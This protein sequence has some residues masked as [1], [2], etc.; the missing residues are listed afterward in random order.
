[1]KDHKIGTTV[2]VLGLRGFPNVQGGVET[3][4]ENLYPLIAKSGIGVVCATRR[5]FHSPDLLEWSGVRF[6]PLWAPKSR[7]LEAIGHSIWAVFRAA[8]MRPSVV[9]IHA[10]GSG[11]VTPLARLFGLRVVVTH[12]GP[13][14]DREK[15]NAF[16]RGILRL[17]EWCGMKFAHERIVISPV[18]EELVSQQ[19]GKTST[20]IPNGVPLP[21][22]EYEEK[23]IDKYG[24]QANKYVLLVSRFVP[25]KRHLD[26]IDAFERVDM[27][28]IKLVLV[29]GAD[30]PDS[31]EEQ[32]IARAGENKNIVLTGILGGRELQSVYQHAGV[33]VLPS[34]HEGLPICLLEALSFGLRC[35]ASNIPA[36]RSVGLDDKH[37]FPLGDTR[38]LAKKLSSLLQQ[39]WPDEKRDDVRLWVSQRFDWNK[40]AIETAE[41][42]RKACR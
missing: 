29:G 16:A 28:G 32:V 42:Y 40:I 17:G 24:L 21:E 39:P 22:L 34:S 13:D 7:F 41:V 30:H 20:V 38:V 23:H 31:Y 3:H 2:F 4:A 14:Y 26:L 12:H 35:L 8:I 19:Y 27:Q 10:V 6:L 18:I 11:L 36:N 15:W 37:Y 33:F 5:R 9:H 1:V 25:E